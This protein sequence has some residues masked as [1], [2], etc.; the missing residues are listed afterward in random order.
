MNPATSYDPIPAQN[1]NT[2]ESSARYYIPQHITVNKHESSSH[3]SRST[4]NLQNTK[5]RKKKA[6]RRE[7]DLHVQKPPDRPVQRVSG[8]F[9]PARPVRSS[10]DVQRHTQKHKPA[11]QGINSLIQEPS[12]HHDRSAKVSSLNNTGLGPKVK[13]FERNPPLR[14]PL[15]FPS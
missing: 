5:E 8:I 6:D 11:Q 1:Q 4:T 15:P 10:V 3:Q 14:G 12:G 13:P 9:S 7:A 2:I